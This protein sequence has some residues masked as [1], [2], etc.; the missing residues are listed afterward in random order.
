MDDPIPV[1]E[2]VDPGSQELLAWAR[3]YNES[4]LRDEI[5]YEVCYPSVLQTRLIGERERHESDSVEGV[6][7]QNNIHPCVND[8]PNV[9]WNTCGHV[10]TGRY[11]HHT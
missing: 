11:S 2:P 3:Q 6:R 9:D 4:L 7:L 1:T 8:R 10:W 5:D